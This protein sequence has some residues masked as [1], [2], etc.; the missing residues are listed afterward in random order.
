M[1]THR[2]DAWTFCFKSLSLPLSLSCFFFFVFVFSFSFSPSCSLARSLAC[3]LAC[4]LARFHSTFKPFI[5]RAWLPDASRRLRQRCL[6]QQILPALK[7]VQAFYRRLGCQML[8]GA[9]SS[10]FCPVFKIV[11][12]IFGRAWLPD[13]S[14]CLRAYVPACLPACFALLTRLPCSL[15][16]GPPPRQSNRAQK[17]GGK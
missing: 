4:L 1:L 3:L 15:F 6:G 17:K 9:W 14:R 8:K 12:P 16:F 2:I 5:G 11:K 13:A 10:S 7:H